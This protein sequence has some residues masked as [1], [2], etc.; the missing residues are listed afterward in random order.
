VGQGV[1]HPPRRRIFVAGQ[2]LQAG[3]RRPIL[4]AG[5]LRFRQ[6]EVGRLQQFGG[7]FGIVGQ[8]LAQL[9]VGGLGVPLLQWQRGQFELR[10]DPLFRIRIVADDLRVDLARVRK[11]LGGRRFRRLLHRRIGMVAA[12]GGLPLDLPFARLLRESSH[13]PQD[14]RETP[15][16]QHPQAPMRH[17]LAP[18]D[19]AVNRFQPSR[20]LGPK[21]IENPPPIPFRGGH[22]QNGHEIC[23]PKE[24]LDSINI[25]LSASASIIGERR[26]GEE[27]RSASL[28]FVS[29]RAAGSSASRNR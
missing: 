2:L 24:S 25:A 4:S 3:Q 26:S 12:D 1:D 13:S 21:R 10:R 7:R 14:G 23:L 20:C 16:G 29:A 17:D 9:G 5:R 6:V 28:S 11:I 27:S 18:S 22:S 8:K 19:R 15:H